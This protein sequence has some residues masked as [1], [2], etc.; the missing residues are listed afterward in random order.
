MSTTNTIAGIIA[1]VKDRVEK[2]QS[3]VATCIKYA[4][5]FG[6]PSDTIL[7]TIREC[8]NDNYGTIEQL[9]GTDLLTQ[10]YAAK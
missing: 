6:Y 9:L 7:Q 4:I 2:S 10:I 5:D 3:I 8:A 1:D